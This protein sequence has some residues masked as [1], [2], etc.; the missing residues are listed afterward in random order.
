MVDDEHV[1]VAQKH[2]LANFFPH[3]RPNIIVPAP[4]AEDADE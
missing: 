1:L 4:L 3:P 2:G